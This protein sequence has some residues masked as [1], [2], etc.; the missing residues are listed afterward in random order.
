M[1]RSSPPAPAAPSSSTAPTVDV[2]SARAA[3]AEATAAGLLAVDAPVSG[4]TA[5]AAA[6]TLTFMAG[7]TP[8]AFEAARPLFDVMGSRAVYC[9]ASGAGQAA[10]ICNNMLLGISMI[11]TCEAFTLARK[12][13]LDA[14][15]LYDVVSTSSGACWSVTSY[16]RSR[17]PARLPG[18]PRLRARLRRRAHVEG[19]DAQPASGRHRRR[20]HPAR[21][22]R[23]RALRGPSSPTAAAA[24]T[25]SA[26][27]PWLADRHHAG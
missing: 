26:V 21:W 19:P 13:G 23:R 15:A 9:G 6:G 22:P 4:G 11:G 25:S 20:R 5:G 8:E 12:L 1:P 17:A 3:A 16:C 18:R 14:H 7:G 10:K 24:R 2:D 27:L